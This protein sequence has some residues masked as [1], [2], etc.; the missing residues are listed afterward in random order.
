MNKKILPW[1]LLMCA[2]GL[3]TTAAY[4]SILGL[5]IVFSAVALPV[6]IMGS[7]LEASKLVI[8]TYLHNQWSKTLLGLKIYLTIALIVLSFI[9][10]VGIYGLLSH[11]FNENIA[12]LEVNDNIISNIE[13]KKNRFIEIKSEKTTEQ[14]TLTQ[15]IS[16]LRDALSTGTQ[17]EYKDRETGEIIRTTSSSARKTFENQ[18]N[19]TLESREKLNS[20]IDILNDSITSLEIQ[21]LELQTDETL[22]G[23]LGVVKYLSDT[24]DKP[25]KT[26]STWLILL[27]IFVFDPLAITLVVATNQAFKNLEVKKN[28]YGEDKVLGRL[29]KEDKPILPTPQDNIDKPNDLS[30]PHP[31]NEP[32][33]YQSKID[34]INSSGY[35]T[36]KRKQM[37]N[38]LNTEEGKTY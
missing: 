31:I 15:D 21:I 38:N 33:P 34:Q 3:S 32:S 27:L 26:I 36:K 10:S 17:V 25:I 6:I 23:E 28:I 35:S 37:I 1:L 18:L 16:N 22:N 12:R 7:F 20:Q 19:T 14:Q 2:L 24:L 9:T 30:I 11:G 5:S 4:Y 29:R 13:V 8:A